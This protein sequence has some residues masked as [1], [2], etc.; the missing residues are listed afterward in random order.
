MLGDSLTVN[1]TYTAPRLSYDY[2]KQEGDISYFFVWGA[3]LTVAEVDLISGNFRL[4]KSHIVQDCGKSLNPL[5]DVGQAE[6]GFMFGV[7]YYTMEDPIY[8]EDG[9]LYHRQCLRL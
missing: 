4:L 5:L 9:V 1:G 8:S 3:A 7:G 6:G 2:E